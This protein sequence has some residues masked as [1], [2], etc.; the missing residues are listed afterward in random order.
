MA[1][2]SSFFLDAGVRV[3]KGSSV[4]T[5]IVKWNILPLFFFFNLII[6]VYF[7]I[8]LYVNRDYFFLMILK[9]YLVF[10]G[11]YFR[12]DLVFSVNFFWFSRLNRFFGFFAHLVSIDVFQNI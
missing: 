11:D 6:N 3:L 7:Y 12:F 2:S 10:R 1:S 9:T 5:N 4:V 8:S